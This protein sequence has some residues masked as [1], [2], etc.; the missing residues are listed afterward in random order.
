M[1]PS[2]TYTRAVKEIHTPTR[3]HIPYTYTIK[4]LFAS[5]EFLP[6]HESLFFNWL[7]IDLLIIILFIN[8]VNKNANINLLYIRFCVVL[9]LLFTWPTWHYPLSCINMEYTNLYPYI[10]SI[11]FH[12]LRKLSFLQTQIWRRDVSESWITT[13]NLRSVSSTRERVVGRSKNEIFENFNCCYVILDFGLKL[14]AI[15]SAL[16]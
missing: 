1:Y 4:Y 11:F 8:Y 3:L 2:S 15:S 12:H 9:L 16:A 13:V 7:I 6:S 10:R 14:G 5:G